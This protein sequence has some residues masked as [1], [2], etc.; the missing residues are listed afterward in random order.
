MELYI[1]FLVV[2]LLSAS[3][4]GLAFRGRLRVGFVTAAMAAVF[5]RIA[6]HL[7]PHMYWWHD[8]YFYFHVVENIL[9]TG[10]FIPTSEMKQWFGGITVQSSWP[11]Y[12]VLTS[13][14][15]LV[16]GIEPTIARNFFPAALSIA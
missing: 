14:V 5:V 11:L 7:Q 8:P 2:G 12:H 13:E 6:P 16:T 4:I 1:Y 10:S 9:A 15:I 3:T